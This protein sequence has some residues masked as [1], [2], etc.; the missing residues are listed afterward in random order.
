MLF[1]QPLRT[2]SRKRAKWNNGITCL[3]LRAYAI[4]T[5]STSRRRCQ[6]WATDGTRYL[7][8]SRLSL[9]ISKSLTLWQTFA[10]L[11]LRPIISPSETYFTQK[12][13]SKKREPGLKLRLFCV[14]SKVFLIRVF[15][16]YMFISFSFNNIFNC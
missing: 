15:F 9:L 7:F 10:N 11:V 5:A 3:L 6:Q 2:S 1:H 4:N 8:A 14:V 13:D 16:R 12:P